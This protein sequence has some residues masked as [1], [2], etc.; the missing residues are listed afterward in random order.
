MT[1]FDTFWGY[2][3][4]HFSYDPDT[5][6]LMRIKH[7]AKTGTRYPIN[8]PLKS[9]GKNGYF[10]ISIQRKRYYNHRIA[11]LLMTGKWPKSIDH[12]N[13]NKTDNRW[14][15]L[16]EVTQEQNT[17]NQKISK[18]NKSGFVGVYWCKVM[19][20]WAADIRANGKSKYLGC[21]TNKLDAYRARK[22]AEKK[23]GFHVNHGRQENG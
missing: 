20:K 21:Y 19:G 4:E 1:D 16:R 17:K 10:R 3:K 9:K 5:G 11:W 23:Y 12:I 7:P 2:V 14:V 8:V 15:N 22:I 18:R 13:G 6:N